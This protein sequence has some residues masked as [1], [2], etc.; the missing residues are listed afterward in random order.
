MNRS[1]K[2]KRVGQ[3][4]AL[5]WLRR[6]G[7]DFS[8]HGYHYVDRGGTAE[9]SRQLGVSEH[10]VI[11]TLLMQDDAREPLIVLMHGDREVTTKNLACGVG[12]D[13]AAR[14]R[15]GRLRAMTQPACGPRLRAHEGGR[16]GSA[17][18]GCYESARTAAEERQ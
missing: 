8:E 13:R 12:T 10:E 4:P 16:F 15:A 17:P 9:S 3:T 1:E 2:H 14:R 6:H 7:V 5:A 18:R 11:K